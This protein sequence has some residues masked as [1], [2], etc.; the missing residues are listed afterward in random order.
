MITVVSGGMYAGK[1]E[2]LIRLLRR[3][4]YARKN[5]I[6]FKPKIDARYH[7]TDIASHA[8]VTFTGIPV[9]NP[10]NIIPLAADYDVVGIDEAQFYDISIIDV[11]QTLANQGKEVVVAGLD[12]DSRGIPFGSMPQ[13]M[14]I[15]DHVYKVHAVCVVCGAEASKTQRIADSQDQILV[16]STNAYQA[17]CRKH[18]HP[19][20]V[21]HEIEVQDE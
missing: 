6:A 15:A 20:P 7:P 1:S 14:A 4:V 2:E 12:Q 3:S 13:L 18:W 9:G 10:M 17:R 16:G 19:E 8:G 5:V 21:Q 11:V